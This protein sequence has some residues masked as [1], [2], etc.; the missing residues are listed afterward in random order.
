[1]PKTRPTVYRFDGAPL[2]AGREARDLSQAQVGAA[3]G[4]SQPTVALA[5]LGIKRPAP[6]TLARLCDVVGVTIDDLF[7]PDDAP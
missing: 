4:V 3:A 5:E 7:V 6:E 1:V 2:R